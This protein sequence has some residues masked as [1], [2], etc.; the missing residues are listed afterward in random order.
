MV[1]RYVALDGAGFADVDIA[2]GIDITDQLAVDADGG[3]AFDITGY[4][5]AGTDNGL[6][7]A[8]ILASMFF[9][10]KLLLRKFILTLAK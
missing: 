2:G 1:C 3:R 7:L 9:A 4:G 10:Q 6:E 8:H 5:V